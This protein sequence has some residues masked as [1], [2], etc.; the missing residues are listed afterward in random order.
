MFHRNIISVFLLAHR[1]VIGALDSVVTPVGPGLV[2]RHGGVAHQHQVG[3]PPPLAVG[4]LQGEAHPRPGVGDLHVHLPLADRVGTEK[5]FG[6][7]FLSIPPSHVT[8][9]HSNR[10]RKQQQLL[11]E[12][13]R[14]F[15]SGSSTSTV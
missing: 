12:T 1:E 5:Y 7:T 13:K 9:S 4:Q 10:Q 11:R 8:P 15:N 6:A 3:E 2:A 14:T